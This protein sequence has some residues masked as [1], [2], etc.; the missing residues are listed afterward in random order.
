MR[1]THD[2]SHRRVVTSLSLKCSL[3]CSLKWSLKRSFLN[4]RGD[5]SVFVSVAAGDD[6]SLAIDASGSV[7][8]WG[9]GDK[10]WN[11]RSGGFVSSSVLSY[12]IPRRVQGIDD[13]DITNATFG[14]HYLA[15]LDKQETLLVF[16]YITVHYLFKFTSN[17]W[18]LRSKGY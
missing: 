9:G 18:V 17:H 1:W 4:C 14:K 8:I 11:G 16:I 3:K 5:D 2:D 12:R 15:L 6:S 10:R 13:Y 7:W